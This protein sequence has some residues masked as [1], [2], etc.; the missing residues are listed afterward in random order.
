MMLAGQAAP[1][2]A[3]TRAAPIRSQLKSALY[4]LKLDVFSS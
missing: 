1:E 3:E 4:Q 2:K